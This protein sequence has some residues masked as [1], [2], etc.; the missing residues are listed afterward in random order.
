MNPPTSRA[1]TA[2]AIVPGLV[3]RA[4]VDSV[5]A[6]SLQSWDRPL[7]ARPPAAIDESR[8]DD[9]GADAAFVGSTRSNRLTR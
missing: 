6:A 3:S 2:V 4:G 9:H 5:T 7:A 1:R 8:V